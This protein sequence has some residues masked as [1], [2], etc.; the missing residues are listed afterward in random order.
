MRI[1]RVRSGSLRSAPVT[2]GDFHM[3]E[4][5]DLAFEVGPQPGM[6]PAD[7]MV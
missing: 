4:F 2:L 1:W 6:E 5:T 3:A 7:K